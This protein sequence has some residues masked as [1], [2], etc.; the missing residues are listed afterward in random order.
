M[1]IAKLIFFA[2][3]QIVFFAVPVDGPTAEYS[4]MLLTM[5]NV[6]MIVV[7]LIGM[8]FPYILRFISCIMEDENGQSTL[9]GKAIIVWCAP[10]FLVAKGI[11]DA[12]T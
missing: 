6:V 11:D 9:F 5:S 12:I 8:Y 3:A 4:K 7:L 10:A 2:A 1:S